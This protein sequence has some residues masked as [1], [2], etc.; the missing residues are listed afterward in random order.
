MIVLAAFPDEDACFNRFFC[1]FFFFR[2]PVRPSEVPE[3]R[4][5]HCANDSRKL[6]E[7][8]LSF[9]KSH[10]LMDE[11]VP[12]FFSLPLLTHTSLR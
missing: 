5:G 4:P 7:L 8:T 6:P 3:P 9:V 10:S 1:L 11:T 2:L 12:A